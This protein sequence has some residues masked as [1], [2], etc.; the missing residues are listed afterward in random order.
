MPNAP[1]ARVAPFRRYAAPP[2]QPDEDTDMKWPLSAKPLFDALMAI[3]FFLLMA[4][5]HTGNVAHECLGVALIGSLL[6][7]TWF[8]RNWYTTLYK[9]RYNF[10]RSIRLMLNLLLLATLVGTL[11]SAVVIS[12]TIFSFM[13][14][15]GELFSRTV[16]IFFAHW[17]FVLAAVHL[18]LYWKRLS[19]TIRRH[20]FLPYPHVPAGSWIFIRVSLAVYGAYAFLQRELSYPLTMR[21]AFMAWGDNDGLGLF[22]LD[23]CAVFFLCA[24]TASVL[25]RLMRNVD[26]H[27]PRPMEN[28]N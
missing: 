20:A 14:F 3:L 8:N 22:L 21:S 27:A 19:A 1:N 28:W 16:H 4:D 13:G 25:S 2:Q 7:H 18:G 6:L 5:R 10:S 15:K 24:W 12:K 11:A 9:G 17:C 23:Y 26:G